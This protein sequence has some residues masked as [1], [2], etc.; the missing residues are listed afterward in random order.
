MAAEERTGKQGRFELP[1]M[2][3]RG[4]AAFVEV[5]QELRQEL[6]QEQRF[7]SNHH[8][9]FIGVCCNDPLLFRA[10]E[11]VV[12]SGVA[13]TDDLRNQLHISWVRARMLIRYLEEK[14]VVGPADEQGHREVLLVPRQRRCSLTVRDIQAAVEAR[15]GVSHEDLVGSPRSRTVMPARREAMYLCRELL[16]LSN[17]Q[18]GEAFNRD[19]ATVISSNLRFEEALAEDPALCAEVESLTAYLLDG[20]G[21]L[22]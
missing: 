1:P 18:I 3:R 4:Q 10:A 5:D 21:A 6:R 7:C 22:G 14:G 19:Y 17:K 9:E 2:D 15:H 13:S 16:G 11:L 20:A 12:S 8:E